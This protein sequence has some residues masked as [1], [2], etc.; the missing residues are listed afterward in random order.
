M[1]Y[2]ALK[3]ARDTLLA[4]IKQDRDDISTLEQMKIADLIEKQTDIVE[5][6]RLKWNTIITNGE[7]KDSLI[8]SNPTAKGQKTTDEEVRGNKR[9]RAA[10]CPSSPEHLNTH[11]TTP[12]PKKRSNKSKKYTPPPPSPRI[13]FPASAPTTL[14]AEFRTRKDL[15][16][17]EIAKFA[18]VHPSFDEST[19][20][21]ID[22]HARRINCTSGIG[23]AAGMTPNPGTSNQRTL[24]EQI[25]VPSDSPEPDLSEQRMQAELI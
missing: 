14:P 23:M 5:K 19:G 21:K 22:K 25:R 11:S 15:T 9:K 20:Q 6:L 8:D 10:T 1:R 7:E 13:A 4:L 2:R 24:E 18:K 17:K 16:T 3:N 12:P